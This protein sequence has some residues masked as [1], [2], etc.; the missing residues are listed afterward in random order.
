MAQRTKE[1]LEAGLAEIRKSPGDGGVLVLLVRRPTEGTRE[2]LQEAELDAERGL[3]G[4]SWIDRK[5]KRT[6]DGS[7]HP[8]M[9][10]NIMNA[11]VAALVAV[12]P[13]RRELAGDQ[14]FLDMDLSAANLPPGT[15][16]ALGS[17]LLEITTL[18]HTGCGKFVERFGLAAQA[19]VNSPLGRELNLRG[20]NARVIK[21]GVVREGDV[22]RKVGAEGD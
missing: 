7:P 12:D 1:E 11:R 8:E 6:P 18:P 19:F 13:A 22:A 20:L 4:D 3:V 2:R 9:Q 10:I 16:I 21:G 17:A 15:R 5:S 14:I